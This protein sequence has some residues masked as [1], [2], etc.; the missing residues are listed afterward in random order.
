MVSFSLF[1]SPGIPTNIR[2][3]IPIQFAFGPSLSRAV[4]F[5]ETSTASNLEHQHVNYPPPWKSSAPFP[6]HDL[7]LPVTFTDTSDLHIAIDNHLTL[8]VDEHITKFNYFNSGFQILHSIMKLFMHYRQTHHDYADLL[9]QALKLLVL[10]HS[11]DITVP[12]DN[13]SVQEILRRYAPGYSNSTQN[14][15]PCILRAELGKI[16]PQLAHFLLEDVLKKLFRICLV[17]RS[18]QHPIVI[19]T[20]SVLMMAVER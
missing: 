9:R 20:F 6:T 11:S 13:T 10:I 2:I 7:I 17:K 14:V 18:D 12:A 8:L 1:Y 5:V 16:V 4:Q 3:E 19:G 15:T